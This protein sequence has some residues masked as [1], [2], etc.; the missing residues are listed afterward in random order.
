MPRAARDPRT[1]PLPGDALRTSNGLIYRVLDRFV[2]IGGRTGELPGVFC[3]VETDDG[4]EK[5]AVL[6]LGVFGAKMREAEVVDLA[7]DG[8][9]SWD[10]V[11]RH[12]QEKL[13]RILRREHGFD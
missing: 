9:P 5:P 13:D 4:D 6:A 1:S 3:A 8:D 11:P 2:S 10:G 12:P 7:A